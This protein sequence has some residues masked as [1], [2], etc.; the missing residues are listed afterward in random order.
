VTIYT[1]R[2]LVLIPCLT[3]GACLVGFDVA[4]QLVAHGHDPRIV[5]LTLLACGLGAVAAR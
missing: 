3:L 2:K 1:F 5:G 4:G